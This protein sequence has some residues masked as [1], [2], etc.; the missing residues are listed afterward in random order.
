[1]RVLHVVASRRWTG[2]AAT[3]LQLVEAL[4]GVGVDA[5]L[6]YQRGDNLAVRLAG[7]EWARAGLCK[8]R[9]P[10]DLIANL[11]A[12]RAEAGGADLVHVHLPHD[13]ALARAATRRMHLPLVR[14]VHRGRHLRPDPYN[15]WLFHRCGAVGLAHAEMVPLCDRLTGLAARPRA[16]LPVAVEPRFRPGPRSSSTRA[17]LGLPSD[18]IVAG[19]VGKVDHD[20]GQ[21]L[22]LH[23]LAATPGVRGMIVGTG[24]AEATFRKLARRL[25]VEDRVV[26]AGYVEAGLEEHYRAMDL[27]VF[28]AAGSD[29][30]HRAIAEAS[31]CG[32]PAL[33]ADLPGV[34]D[35]VEAGVTGA[36]YPRDDAAALAVLLHDWALNPARI[37]R[38]GRQAAAR[39]AARWTAERLAAVATGLY[40][41]VL[42]TGSR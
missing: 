15:R 21:D 37:S 38:C 35:L 29:H 25:A 3:A 26:F 36:L 24:D 41:E 4:R 6:L 22:L 12:V 39:A 40:D 19:T 27:F 32:L 2:A 16:V 14:S 31:A 34:R 30:A 20:R 5:R 11:G 7:S 17:A 28:P 33:A 1:M 8:E 10:A 18:A 23:A 42:G 9:G 13:H